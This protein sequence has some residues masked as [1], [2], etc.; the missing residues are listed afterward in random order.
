MRNPTIFIGY[1]LYEHVLISGTGLA[2]I[3]N[4]NNIYIFLRRRYLVVCISS[5]HVP[6]FDILLN[7][8]DIVFFY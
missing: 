5:Q 7:V 3:N 4:T 8:I 2:D 6:G 1:V